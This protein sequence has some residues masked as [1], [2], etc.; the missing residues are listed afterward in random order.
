VPS[1]RA[2]IGRTIDKRAFNRRFLGVLRLTPAGA[3]AMAY[4]DVTPTI[5]AL[6]ERPADFALRRRAL[7]HTPSHHVF[8]FSGSG[9]A[10]VDAQC[11]CAL[12]A[13]SPE[14]SIQ[15]K[16]AFD[17]WHREHWRVLEINREFAKHFR[18]SLA[19]R[20]LGALRGAFRAAFGTPDVRSGA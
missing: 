7:V 13:I 20:F 2:I 15:L 19:R 3:I 14:Q 11:D 4:L 1:A 8:R 12:L 16:A 18:P 6:R 17:V 5:D 10:W 9:G